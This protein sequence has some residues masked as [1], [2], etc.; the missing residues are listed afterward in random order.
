M[1]NSEKQKSEFEIQLKDRV[2]KLESDI[3]RI[4]NEK[5]D[6]KFR[7]DKTLKEKQGIEQE[8]DKFK[9]EA[10]K[11]R[12]DFDSNLAQTQRINVMFEGAKG[13]LGQVKQEKEYLEKELEKTKGHYYDAEK[14]SNDYFAE[15]QSVKENL[16]IIK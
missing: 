16:E 15:L 11:T 4:N 2:T 1:Q 10:L 8:V 9:Y 5:S 14:K 12:G 13:E 3:D 6:L 7:L